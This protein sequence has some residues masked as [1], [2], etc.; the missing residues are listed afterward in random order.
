LKITIVEDSPYIRKNLI[1]FISEIKGAEITGEAEDVEYALK[2][3]EDKSPDIIILDIELKNSNGFDLLNKIKS[4]REAAPLVMMFSNLSSLSYKE[5]ALKGKADY[6]FDK[7]N[8]FDE[9]ITTIECLIK[10]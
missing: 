3:V 9:L 10:K 6:F 2:L 7:T 8:D 5:K 4:S 1:R